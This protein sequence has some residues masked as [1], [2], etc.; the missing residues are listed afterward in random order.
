MRSACPSFRLKSHSR[1]FSIHAGRLPLFFSFLLMA[2]NQVTAPRP[3]AETAF[4]N[5]YS[6]SILHKY[7]SLY[8]TNLKSGCLSPIGALVFPSSHNARH[9]STFP[10][11][12]PAARCEFSHLQYALNIVH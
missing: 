4:S 6:S 8:N 1:T 5:N 11:R 2:V 10:S 3:S 7:H 12:F 9:F